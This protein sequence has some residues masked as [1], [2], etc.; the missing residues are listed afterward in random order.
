MRIPEYI[1]DLCSDIVT[2]ASHMLY[3]K[4]CHSPGY[5]KFAS[6]ILK[7]L[8]VIMTVVRVISST[9]T[10]IFYMSWAMPSYT[11]HLFG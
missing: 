2:K 7:Y 8:L 6:M 9:S 1:W 10:I 4:D 3:L 5:V 11:A